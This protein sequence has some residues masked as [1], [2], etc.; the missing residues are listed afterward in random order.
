MLCVVRQE[1]NYSASQTDTI[2]HI[3][4][5]LC[6]TTQKMLLI[7]LAMFEQM[8]WQTTQYYHLHQLGGGRQL[9]MNGVHSELNLQNYQK[10]AGS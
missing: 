8:P 4:K 10:H 2:F 5:N 1:N 3:Y 7:K 6:E 9:M